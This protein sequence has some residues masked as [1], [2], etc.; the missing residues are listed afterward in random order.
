MYSSWMSIILKQMLFYPHNSEKMDTEYL[1][2]L[3]VVIQPV[4]FGIEIWIQVLK[5]KLPVWSK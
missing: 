3:S 5:T 1:S 4:S 2:N